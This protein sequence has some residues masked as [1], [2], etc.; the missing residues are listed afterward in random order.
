MTRNRGKR[1]TLGMLVWAVAVSFAIV[2]DAAPKAENRSGTGG[3]VIDDLDKA[4]EL[5]MLAA[6][7]DSATAQAFIEFARGRDQFSKAALIGC[8]HGR[9][10]EMAALV[11]QEGDRRLAAGILAADALADFWFSENQ[12]STIYRNLDEARSRSG[13]EPGAGS[14]RKAV[15]AARTA[16]KPGGR[17]GSGDGGLLGQLLQDSDAETVRLALMAAAY[18][19]DDGLK[20]QVAALPVAGPAAAGAVLL[21]RVRTGDAL[22]D[23]EASSLFAAALRGSPGPH[24]GGGLADFS[25]DLPG[26][27]MACQAAA[28]W[29][30]GRTLVPQLHAA[31]SAPDQRIQVEAV[32]AIGTIGAPDSVPVLIQRLGNCSWPV[33]VEVTKA[34]GAIPDARSIPPLLARLRS[35]RGRFRLDLVYAL[36]SIAGEQKGPTAEAWERWW[37]QAAMTFRPNSEATQA[38]RKAMRVQDMGVPSLGRFYSLPIYSERICFVVDSSQSMRGERMASLRANLT[39]AVQTLEDHV[40]YN[41]VNF[42]GVIEAMR[43]GSLLREKR[44]A[45]RRIEDMG[46]TSGTRSYDAME[47]GA[48]MEEVDT[49]YFLSDGKPTPSQV[50][51]WNEIRRAIVLCGRHRPLAFYVVEF[52]LEGNTVPMVEM[53]DENYGLYEAVVISGLPEEMDSALP[54]GKAPQAKKDAGGKAGAVKGAG[55]AAPKKR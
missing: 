18:R 23:D 8:M 7:R 24:S 12:A 27:V 9:P 53:S 28:L 14:D 34:L 55:K 39:Q 13:T 16:K 45:Y 46:Y 2:V 26:G 15:K 31:L 52:N 37:R 42:G 33:L 25:L 54:G 11:A 43:Q 38:F 49:I 35:E 29:K 32:R 21:Y 47:V 10:G 41:I 22:A 40:A 20:A 6:R 30:G 17:K 44:S 51:E 3:V 36:S 1:G 50:S 48:R 19:G 4:R 5:G